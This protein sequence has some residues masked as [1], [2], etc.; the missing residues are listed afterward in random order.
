MANVVKLLGVWCKLEASL[1][2][3]WGSVGQVGER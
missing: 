1:I 3:F 2:A